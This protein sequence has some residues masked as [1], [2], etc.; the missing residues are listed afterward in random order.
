MNW[1]EQHKQTLIELYPNLT[2]KE[3]GQRFGVS[4]SAISVMA[5]KLRLFKTP[6][7]HQKVREA[8]QFKKGQKP[9]NK[10]KKWSEFMSEQ[11]KINSSKTSFKKGNIP[12]NHKP[13]GTEVI[14]P[15]DRYVKIKVAEPNNWMLK[16]RFVWEQ[17][18]GK[19]PKGFNVQFINKDRTDCR[20]E[21]LY[22]IH[23]KEQVA[24]NSIIRY[25]NDLRK[26][27]YRIS[28]IQKLIKQNEN[29]Y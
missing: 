2:N 13:V 25:P 17:H 6:E 3:L 4:E 19:I 27:I 12:V 26:S 16:H 8:T 1:T 20:I 5:W 24:Q 28:K 22:L 21:N 11:S 29:K 10:G 7:F 18:N 9:F 23:R 15:K 14:E